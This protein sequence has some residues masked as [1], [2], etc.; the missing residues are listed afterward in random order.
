MICN[1][2][3]IFINRIQDISDSPRSNLEICDLERC[4]S[5]IELMLTYL[6]FRIFLSVLPSLDFIISHFHNKIINNLSLLYNTKKE[7]ECQLWK[8]LK[9]QLIVLRIPD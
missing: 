8:L 7:M 3:N 9:M 2:S 1:L 4:S 6:L 5:A